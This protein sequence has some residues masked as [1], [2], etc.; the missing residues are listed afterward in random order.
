MNDD[1]QAQL[2]T[3]QD[4]LNEF[5]LFVRD[6]F[7]RVENRFEQADTRFERIDR[8]LL[9]LNDRADTVDARL[10]VIDRKLG[11]VEVTLVD[12]QDELEGVARAVDANSVAL[13]EQGTR[14]EALEHAV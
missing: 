12:I 14:M 4:T 8:S 9:A 2:T 5:I 10:G 13:I 11:K 6:Q 1:M 7:E 3:L